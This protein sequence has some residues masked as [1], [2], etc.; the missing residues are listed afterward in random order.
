[1]PHPPFSPA[2][3]LFDF[4]LFSTI[5]GKLRR[6]S[7]QGAGELIEGIGDVTG[8]IRPTELDGVLRNWKDQLQRRI[9]LGGKY[10]D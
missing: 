1:V 7:S 3:T 2:S 8:S 5:K 10:I 9:E 4:Y 6:R